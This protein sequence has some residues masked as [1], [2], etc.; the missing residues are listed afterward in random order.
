M[1][2]QDLEEQKEIFGVEALE[3]VLRTYYGNL[4]KDLILMKLDDSLNTICEYLQTHDVH[5]YQSFRTIQVDISR[6]DLALFDLPKS[7]GEKDFAVERI[8]ELSH[9]ASIQA[10]LVAKYINE[11][12]LLES[13]QIR[14]Y[15][16]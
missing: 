6:K 9:S 2:C 14:I 12:F 4:S 15:T 3:K 5:M 13:G 11:N 16:H 10:D 7:V 1:S 8:S